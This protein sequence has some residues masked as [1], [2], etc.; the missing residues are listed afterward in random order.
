MKRSKMTPID[1]DAVVRRK[2]CAH[3]RNLWILFVL[4]LF[5]CKEEQKTYPKDQ[6]TVEYSIDCD[7]IQLG[8]PAELTMR[9]VYP[10]GGVLQLP[11]IG[12]DKEIV[13]LKRDGETLTREDGLLETTTH[14]RL[15]S[16][17]LG[18][19][20]VSTNAIRCAVNDETLS[21]DFPEVVLHVKSALPADAPETLADIKPLRKLPWIIPLWVWIVLGAALFAFLAGIITTKLWKG[22]KEKI[23]VVPSLPP[24][25]IALKALDALK[26][27]GLLE[28]DKCAP[29]YTELSLILRTYLEGQFHLNAPDETTE[30]IVEEMSRSIELNG[31]QQNILKEFMYQADMVKF[32]RGRPERVTMESAFETTRQ[33][34]TETKQTFTTKSSEEHR[35]IP[36]VNSVSSSE[37]GGKK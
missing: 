29:F 30:E 32:A 24:D 28:K 7:S 25:V 18:D 23:V 8:D 17:R 6:L 16:F 13:L 2:I 4:V 12:R 33:F 22:R 1:T 3:L 20:T 15:T 21:A 37:V 9:A 34:V 31:A 10:K 14:L 35:E 26:A 11:E 19:F 27:K 36:S 5:G